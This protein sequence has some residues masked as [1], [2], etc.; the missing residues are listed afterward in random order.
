[1]TACMPVRS[2]NRRMAVSTYFGSTL[3]AAQ[4]TGRRAACIEIEPKY[5]DTAIRRF[6]DL[7]GMQAVHALWDQTFSE[8]EKEKTNV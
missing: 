6:E 3:L 4:Q 2:S 1:C 8:I 5:V 7:T